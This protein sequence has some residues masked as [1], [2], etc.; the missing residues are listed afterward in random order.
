MLDGQGVSPPLKDTGYHHAIA[1]DVI[2]RTDPAAS[3]GALR[4]AGPPEV[5]AFEQQDVADVL[6]YALRMT[7]RRGAPRACGANRSAQPPRP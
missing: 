1:A 7:R 5:A 2:P 6:K 3:P 4:R